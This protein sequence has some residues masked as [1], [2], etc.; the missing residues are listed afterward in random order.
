[1][2]QAVRREWSKDKEYGYKMFSTLS[3]GL[4]SRANVMLA[5][6]LGFVNQVFGVRK[7]NTLIVSHNHTN[8][9]KKKGNQKAFG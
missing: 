1:M 2:V 6:E 3:G 5:R 8:C 9:S 7:F 4:D